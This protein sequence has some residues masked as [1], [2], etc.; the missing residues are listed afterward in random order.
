M[1]TTRVTSPSRSASRASNERPVRISSIAL[2]LPT[3][4]VS[5]C[6]PPAPGITPIRIS[7]WPNCASSPAM[8][9]SHAIASSQPPPRANPRT[10]AISGLRMARSSDHRSNSPPL[11]SDSGVA[12]AISLM[13]APAANAR[14]PAPVMTMARTASSS[15]RACS[16]SISCASRSKL[17]ALSASGRRSVTSATPGTSPSGPRIGRSTRTRRREPAFGRPFR[18]CA[19]ATASVAPA[20]GPTSPPA[21]MPSTGASPSSRPR[22]RSSPA[23]PPP[24]PMPPPPSS[25]WS[26]CRTCLLLVALLVG[27]QVPA[28]LRHVEP[29]RHERLVG[30]RRARRRVR[31]RRVVVGERRRLVDV[32]AAGQVDRRATRR[33]R[34][35]PPRPAR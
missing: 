32:D 7:G 21:S 25:A 4:R 12:S 9:M 28:R 6:V 26:C 13:S 33:P 14:S 31:A 17:R 1:G 11:E 22:S 30:E 16:A 18:R 10:A 35:R 20:P 5:R 29:R 2:A 19:A 8:I 15:S 24:S 34:S 23:G 3:A 27:R